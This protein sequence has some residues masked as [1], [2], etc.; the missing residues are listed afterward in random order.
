MAF[1]AQMS[2]RFSQ[3]NYAQEAQYFI[4]ATVSFLKHLYG[5][6]FSSPDVAMVKKWKYSQP[7]G[8]ARFENVNPPGSRLIIASD[9]LAG[10]HIEDAFEC[11]WNAA[12]LLAKS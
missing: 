6:E 5:E 1:V 12:E 10:G 4:D 11:G 7:E 2:A 8:L 3:Q 9:G